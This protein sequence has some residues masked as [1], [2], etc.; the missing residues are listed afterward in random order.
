MLERELN[1]AAKVK[2]LR[3][4]CGLKQDTLAMELGV[5]QAAVS[6]W[7]RGVRLPPPGIQ[8][9]IRKRLFSSPSNRLIRSLQQTVTCNPSPAVLFKIRGGMPILAAASPRAWTDHQIFTPEDLDEFIGDKAGEEAAATHI[10]LDKEGLYSGEIASARSFHHNRRNGIE[11]Q[12]V[13]HYIPFLVDHGD[14][15]VI[16]QYKEMAETEFEAKCDAS[17][18]RTFELSP[19]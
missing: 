6:Q 5:S 1:W 7:E 13:V 16:A 4:L 8:D 3:H 9:E 15:R 18:V 17:D 19:W 11:R 10:R 2:E 12:G 14:W